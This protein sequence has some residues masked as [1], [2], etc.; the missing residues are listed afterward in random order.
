MPRSSYSASHCFKVCNQ[1]CWIVKSKYRYAIS[2]TIPCHTYFKPIISHVAI[3]GIL[4]LGV[5]VATNSLTSYWNMLCYFLLCHLHVM[6]KALCFSFTSISSNPLELTTLA[7]GTSTMVVVTTIPARWVNDYD[8][9]FCD[10]FFVCVWITP[11]HLLL[12]PSHPISI[13]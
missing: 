2:F 5:L 3:I 11:I 7:F 12:P 6:W 10:T 8:G 13:I 9:Q 4:I 1:N